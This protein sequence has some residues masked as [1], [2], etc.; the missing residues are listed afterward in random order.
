MFEVTTQENGELT[1]LTVRGEVD[2][3]VAP[4]LW[5]LIEKTIDAGR[6][7]KVR[8]ADVSYI[9][10]SGIATLIRGL[11]H[12]QKKKVDYSLLEPSKRVLDVLELAQLDRLFSI[13]SEV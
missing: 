6:P 1:V 13:E 7:L 10:S 12:A 3:E 9:D 5:S 2:L 11:K 8:L 4:E